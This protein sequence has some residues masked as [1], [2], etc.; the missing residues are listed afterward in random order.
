M[1][2]EQLKRYFKNRPGLEKI[3]MVGEAVFIDEPTA[4]KYAAQVK[5]LVVARRESDLDKF[6]PEE[7]KAKV[8]NLEFNGDADYY[9]M[10]ALVEALELKVGGKSKEAYSTALINK[11][12]E[13][14][15]ESSVDTTEAVE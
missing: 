12:E 11:K 1:T 5:A 3:Y 10:K 4:K 9:I 6:T 2:N 7:A 8:L 14:A 15:N 13:L